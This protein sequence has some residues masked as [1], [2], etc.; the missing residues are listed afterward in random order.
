MVRFS[1][2]AGHARAMGRAAAGAVTGAAALLLELL[3]D[4]RAV[5]CCS[6]SCYSRCCDA[7]ARAV[8]RR[9]ARRAAARASF[10]RHEDCW[11]SA[12][13]IGACECCAWATHAYASRHVV[14][15]SHAYVPLGSHGLAVTVD[16]W[17]A[18]LRLRNRTVLTFGLPTLRGSLE[19]WL[20]NIARVSIPPPQPPA[21]S[22]YLTLTSGSQGS[23]P[24]SNT[25]VK[26]SPPSRTSRCDA[27]PI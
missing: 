24:H 12:R 20:A 22:Q 15:H 17:A 16:P 6:R 13:G 18:A 10:P 26:S 1:C 3:F 27:N 11:R 9:T 5:R 19:F 21:P 25:S 14:L 23:E 8:A 2:G 7:A 4:S